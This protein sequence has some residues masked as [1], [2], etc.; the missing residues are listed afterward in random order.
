MMFVRPQSYGLMLY[1]AAA[2]AKLCAA[3][4]LINALPKPYA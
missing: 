1:T 3:C 4:C 2:E